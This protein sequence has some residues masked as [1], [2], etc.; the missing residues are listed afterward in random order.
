MKTDAIDMVSLARSVA[1]LCLCAL[2]C[3]AQQPP[4]VLI[5]RAPGITAQADIPGS[6][7]VFTQG[8]VLNF[9]V[10]QPVSGLTAQTDDPNAVCNELK[11]K[12]PTITV[13]EPDFNATIEAFPQTAPDDTLLSTQYALSLLDIQSAWSAGYLGSDAI[14]VCMTDTGLDRLHPDL[15]QHV[16]VN[17]GEIP[18]NGIDDDN[19]GIIDDVYGAAFVNGMGSNDIQDQQ[20]HGTFVSGVIGGGGQQQPG[21]CWDGPK[22]YNTP[23]QIHGRFR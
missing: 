21:H 8:A 5:Q 1:C 18:N 4:R 17:P 16:W 20:G 22:R 12:D 14:K 6:V 13:S 11:S 3:T 23:M 2:C 9:G 7:N 15:M 10:V 19:N